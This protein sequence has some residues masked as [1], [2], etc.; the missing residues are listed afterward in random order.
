MTTDLSWERWVRFLRAVGLRPSGRC[1]PDGSI[2]IVPVPQ[3]ALA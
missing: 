2:E 1:L 3:G